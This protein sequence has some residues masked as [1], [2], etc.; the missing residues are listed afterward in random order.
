[1]SSVIVITVIGREKLL[2]T[3]LLQITVQC[4]L[5]QK[6]DPPNNYMILY[7]ICFLLFILLL[8]LLICYLYYYMIFILTLNHSVWHLDTSE[9]LSNFSHRI[10]S[11]KLF[12]RY[13]VGENY[14]QVPP[15]LGKSK[16]NLVQKSSMSK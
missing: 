14:L 7:L 13:F 2:I 8:L 12:N 1:M 3:E 9:R 10:P 16:Q 11:S 4:G 15:G 5:R 6:K